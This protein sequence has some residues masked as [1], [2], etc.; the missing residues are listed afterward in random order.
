MFPFLRLVPRNQAHR[1]TEEKSFNS[2]AVAIGREMTDTVVVICF[3][4]G[5]GLALD[6]LER[7]R[8]CRKLES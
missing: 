5:G 4:D 2:G 7:I 1:K 3:F 6:F 8:M